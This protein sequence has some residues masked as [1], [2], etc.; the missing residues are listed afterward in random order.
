MMI[1]ENILHPSEV[2][3]YKKLVEDFNNNY[4]LKIR[5]VNIK[6]NYDDETQDVFKKTVVNTI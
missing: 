5:I 2:G 3:S 4:F 1:S 6:L